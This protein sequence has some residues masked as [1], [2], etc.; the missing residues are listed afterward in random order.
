MNNTTWSGYIE[1]EFPKY[2]N[3]NLLINDLGSLKKYYKNNNIITDY[4]FNITNSES[5]KFIQKFGVKLVTLSPEI[6][7]YE[8]L[9]YTSNTEIITRGYLELMILKDFYLKGDDIYLIDKFGKKFKIVTGSEVKILSANEISI[10]Q[11]IDTST[12]VHL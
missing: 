12:R 3:E 10:N 1:K 6:P 11:K 8:I 5:V 7:D 9:K 4:T 2:E